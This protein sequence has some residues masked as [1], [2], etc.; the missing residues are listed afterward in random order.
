MNIKPKYINYFV[1]S[2]EGFSKKA[3]SVMCFKKML[4][5]IGWLLGNVHYLSHWGK[6]SMERNGKSES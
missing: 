5:N 3:T 1:G 4:L 6:E 2:R